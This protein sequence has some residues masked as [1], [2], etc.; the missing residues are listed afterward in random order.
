MKVR[1]D[2]INMNQTF[3]QSLKV[4]NN[5]VCLGLRYVH[6]QQVYLPALM[7]VTHERYQ[8]I[9]MC[10]N[11]SLAGKKSKGFH[12]NQH[13]SLQTDLLSMPHS[14][15]LFQSA[16]FI[17][18]LNWSVHFFRPNKTDPPVVLHCCMKFA[19]DGPKL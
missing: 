5:F 2:D 1:G 18:L 6:K 10:E 16:D 9:R 7:V 8:C 11:T 12:D 15:A 14:A 13:T 3:M 19:S 17:C 4:K